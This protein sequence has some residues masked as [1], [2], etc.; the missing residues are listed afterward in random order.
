MSNVSMLPT[1]S[2]GSHIKITKHIDK[3]DYGD[4]IV[5]NYD[6]IVNEGEE[7]R[8]IRKNSTI[9]EYYKIQGHFIFRVVG[10]PGDSI[11]VENDICII[12]GT[13][14]ES[15]L[16]RKGISNQDVD[17]ALR[18]Y[19][20]EYSEMLP[21]GINIHIYKYSYDIETVKNMKTIKIPDNHYFLMGDFRNNTFDSRYIGT[22]PKEQ[23]I[24]KVIKIT[25]KKK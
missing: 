18:Q 12:N 15:K 16:I 4:V 10:L 9:D 8:A 2:V 7:M 25:P 24:G 13:E 1:I 20:E 23:I 19:V 21:N 6:G 3:L 11:A 22:A 5:Y 17:E 14:N